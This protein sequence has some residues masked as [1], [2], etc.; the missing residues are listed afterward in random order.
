MANNDQHDTITPAPSSSSFSYAPPPSSSNITTKPSFSLDLDVHAT[1]SRWLSFSAQVWEYLKIYSRFFLLWISL[2]TVIVILVYEHSV[3]TDPDSPFMYQTTLIWPCAIIAAGAAFYDLG[4]LIVR[5]VRHGRGMP[6]K[7]I[8]G[9]ELVALLATLAGIAMFVI[10]TVSIGNI[11]EWLDSSELGI[12]FSVGAMLGISAIVRLALWIR[13]CIDRGR[14]LAAGKP[15]VMYIP[16]TGEIVYLIPRPR[17]SREELDMFDEIKETLRKDTASDVDTARHEEEER[18]LPPLPPPKPVARQPTGLMNPP[19]DDYEPDEA[20]LE[21]RRRGDAQP[22]LI[23][24]PGDTALKFSS[25]ISGASPGGS[26]AVEG[27]VL[28]RP[29]WADSDS[30]RS[31]DVPRRRSWG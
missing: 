4:E 3:S 28:G 22:Q 31:S 16:S 7:A 29:I 9:C 19:P 1:K 24:L 13:A 5:F 15:R 23:L 21:R 18:S 11:A 20:E 2:A 14:E 6:A 26:Y 27:K 8:I 10:Q 30:L 12:T 25:N 17:R